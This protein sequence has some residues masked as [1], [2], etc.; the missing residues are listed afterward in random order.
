MFQEKRTRHVPLSKRLDADFGSDFPQEDAID[1]Y[2][3]EIVVNLEMKSEFEYNF[4]AIV[5][6]ENRTGVD[7]ED[8]LKD[9][10]QNVLKGNERFFIRQFTE[11]MAEAYSLKKI[12]YPIL[13]FDPSTVKQSLIDFVWL[14]P[15]KHQMN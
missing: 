10:L 12:M 3:V 6:E 2:L 5:P 14:K 13:S 1:I 11:D 9:A 4:L 8:L 7:S 15:P